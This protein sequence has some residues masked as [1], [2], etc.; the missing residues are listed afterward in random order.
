MGSMIHS[1]DKLNEEDIVES[2]RRE[3]KKSAR[4]QGSKKVDKDSFGS[5]RVIVNK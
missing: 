4:K 5:D 3:H 2:K 1:K